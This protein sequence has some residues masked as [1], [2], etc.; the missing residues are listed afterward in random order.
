MIFELTNKQREYLGLEI[1]PKSWNKVKITDEVYIYFDTNIIRKK[2]SVN[3]YLYREIK[4]DEKTENRT[5]LLP[6]TKRGKPK[7]LNYSSLDARNGIGTY[8][9]FDISG[10]TIGNFTTQHTYYSTYFE[11]LKFTEL[12]DLKKWL[13]DFISNTSKKDLK[14]IKEFGLRKRKRIKLKEGDFFTFKVDR[15]NYGF[16]RLICDVGKLR[17]LPE[18]KKKKNYGLANLM[19]QPLV[20]QIYHFISP[21]KDVSLE[22]LKNEIKFPSQYIMDNKLFYGDFEIIGNNKL[23]KWE[24][25]F[26]IS[27]SSSINHNDLDIV[28]LQYGK[29]YKDTTT[30]KFNKYLKINNPNPKAEKWDKI[31]LSRPYRNESIGFGLEITKNILEKSIKERSN[32]PYWVDNNYKREYD[33]RNPKNKEIKNE[34]FD[35]FGLDANKSYCDNLMKYKH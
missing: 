14:N 31:L 22:N 13:N 35:F 6:K 16:G 32:N 8:F 25:N 30:K 20:I 34:I 12:N 7:K 2:I 29:I 26:P 19:G 33:L 23:E 15:R 21:E 9:Q 17:K 5:I 1:V 11:N 27:Y 18:F 10:I 3:E 4:L 24:L 28:Y